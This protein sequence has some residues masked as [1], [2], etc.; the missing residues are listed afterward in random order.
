M[1]EVPPEPIELR[2][3]AGASMA[4]VYPG[5]GFNC[6]SFTVRLGSEPIELLWQASGF[7]RGEARPTSSGLPIL[8]PFAGRLAGRQFEYAG[9]TYELL[10]GDTLGNAIHGFACF[11]PWQV[12]ERAADRAVGRFRGADFGTELLSRWPADFVLTA[13]YHVRGSS[14]R[15]ALV[16]E[17]PGPSP[18]PFGLGTHPYFRLPLGPEGRAEDCSITV[19]AT[20]YWE[21]A[22]MLP[23][24]RRLPLAP[25][26]PIAAGMSFGAMQFDDVL[27][28]LT[29]SGPT[30]TA[31][32]DDPRS[33]RRLQFE[34][35]AQF[36][37]C[38]VY[39]PPH[40]QAVCIEPYTTVPDAF[41]LERRGIAAGLRV[42]PAGGR[43][44]AALEIR[45]VSAGAG[46]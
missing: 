36:R 44:S 24:G 29:G 43:Y 40:R 18:L 39:T 17:N 31:T 3:P 32:I 42:L 5:L 14:L 37:Q 38:V 8:F 7:E 35:D 1:P 16:V 27:G 34:F 41:A 9:A 45:L 33:G 23:T 13:S 30:R 15:L 11:R 6:A 46:S 12:V 2:D 26:R 22:D 10:P 20:S 4:L 19:P 28:E 21:L 25:E